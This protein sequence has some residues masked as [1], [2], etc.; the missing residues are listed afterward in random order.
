MA[1]THI[2]ISKI[3]TTSAVSS[4]TLTTFPSTQTDLVIHGR[5]KCS[6]NL[7]IS[8]NINGNSSSIYNFQTM[9]SGPGAQAGINSSYMGILA[10]SSSAA[11]FNTFEM[12]IPQYSSSTVTKTI[13]SRSSDLYNGATTLSLGS[14][15]S[16]TAITSITFIANSGTFSAG[17]VF[18]IYGI[19]AV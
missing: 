1:R 12:W 7:E 16:Q 9:S 3:K 11:Y 2:P 19:K 15:E 13:W 5:Y 6:G 10:P 8:I 18:E 17:A 14:S 4:I